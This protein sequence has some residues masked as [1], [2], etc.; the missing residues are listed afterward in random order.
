M[1]QHGVEQVWREMIRR[2]EYAESI[3]TK[4]KDTAELCGH[5]S[6]KA[7]H[8]LNQYRVAF[9]DWMR[10]VHKYG[11]AINERGDV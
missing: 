4:Y 5:R 10:A 1:D 9:G 11:V 6:K 8:V 7:N 3:Y 2:Q